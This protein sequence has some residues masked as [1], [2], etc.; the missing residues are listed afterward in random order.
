MALDELRTALES[1]PNDT[2]TFQTHLEPILQEGSTDLFDE[3]LET[4]LAAVSDE[5]SLTNLMRAADLKAK[6]VEGEL[7]EHVSYK[8]GKVFLDF[9]GNEDMAEM[10]FRRLPPESSYAAE[11]HDFYVGFY[12][13]KQNWRKLEQHFQSRAELE[14]V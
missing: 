11:L 12:T 10:Y 8:V 1:N 9:I 7:R 13:R 4:V 14:G 6:S 3:F 5:T 2:R